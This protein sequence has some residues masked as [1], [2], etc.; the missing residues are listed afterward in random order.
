MVLEVND[1]HVNGEFCE[2]WSVGES[3]GQEE[4]YTYE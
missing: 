3:N 1:V 4:C 2:D